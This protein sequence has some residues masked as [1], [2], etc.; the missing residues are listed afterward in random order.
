[1]TRDAKNLDVEYVKMIIKSANSMRWCAW[2]PGH[3]VT[4]LTR[5]LFR[6]PSSAFPSWMSASKGKTVILVLILTVIL[7]SHSRTS[8]HGSY[9]PRGQ[10]KHETWPHRYSCTA[11]RYIP[12]HSTFLY[13]SSQDRKWAEMDGASRSEG[14]DDVCVPT[15]D[16]VVERG[17]ATDGSVDFNSPY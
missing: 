3:L 5:S 9:A 8:R 11:V 10:A 2:W 17:P 7:T 4:E 1:M 16:G 12:R 15:T 14:I 13:L 6:L